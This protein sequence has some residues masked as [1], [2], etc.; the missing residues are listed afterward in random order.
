MM[1]PLSLGEEEL[2]V[3]DRDG[4]VDVGDRARWRVRMMFMMVSPRFVFG[5]RCLEAHGKTVIVGAFRAHL[6]SWQEISAAF[7]RLSGPCATDLERRAGVTE[8]DASA[9]ASISKVAAAT[10]REATRRA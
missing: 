8:L 7:R 5:A 3:G 9:S 1:H 10:T 2:K 4:L 6:R